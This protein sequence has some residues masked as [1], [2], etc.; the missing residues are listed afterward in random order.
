[1]FLTIDETFLHT[2]TTLSLHNQINNSTTMSLQHKITFTSQNKHFLSLHIKLYE[3]Q[4]LLINKLQ[5]L[6][7]QFMSN[8]V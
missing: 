7:C 4:F 8:N 6:S 1:M 5:P 3:K 2:L